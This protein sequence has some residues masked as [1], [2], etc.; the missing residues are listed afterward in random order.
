MM[1]IAENKQ[2][3][4]RVIKSEYGGMYYIQKRTAPHRW[5]DIATAETHDEAIN[6]FLE[7][8]KRC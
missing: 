7:W 5:E 6:I 1:I 4:K 2:Y 8:R 3:T